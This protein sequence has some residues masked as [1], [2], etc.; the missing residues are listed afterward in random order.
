M[1]SITNKILAVVKL[2]HLSAPIRKGII[3]YATGS[4]LYAGFKS[5]E[6]GVAGLEQFRKFR[7][8]FKVFADKYNYYYINNEKITEKTPEFTVVRESCFENSF[9]HFWKG[10]TFPF[11]IVTDIVPYI[12]LGLN[13]N[14]DGNNSGSGINGGSGI[15]DGSGINGNDTVTGINDNNCNDNN[16]GAGNDNAISVNKS[17]SVSGMRGMGVYSN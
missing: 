6:D 10:I 15:N 4:V 12:V 9:L 1:T 8:C 5:Y 3:A 16:T 11:Q 7:S 14:D 2:Q 17:I 13:K